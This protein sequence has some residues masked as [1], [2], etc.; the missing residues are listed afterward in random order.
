[1]VPLVVRAEK[2][3]IHQGSVHLFHTAPL[4]HHLLLTL[5]TAVLVVGEPEVAHTEPCVRSATQQ[6]G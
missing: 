3:P 1:M 5:F 2:E 4:S 6:R